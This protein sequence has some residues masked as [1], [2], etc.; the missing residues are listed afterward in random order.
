VQCV[1]EQETAAVAE[2][3]DPYSTEIS[4]KEPFEKEADV[5]MR[6]LMSFPVDV[7]PVTRVQCVS[8]QETADESVSCTQTV[9]EEFD[10]YST[11]MMP[12]M[13][14]IGA[15]KDMTSFPIDALPVA[16]AQETSIECILSTDE[17][18]DS[19]MVDDKLLTSTELVSNVLMTDE[20]SDTIEQ[21]L[22]EQEIPAECTNDEALDLSVVEGRFFK[23]PLV[24]TEFVSYL[25]TSNESPETG[26]HC[27]SKQET[28]A[29]EACASCA[30]SAVEEVQSNWTEM[31]ADPSEEP[32]FQEM[33]PSGADIA[34]SKVTATD[35]SSPSLD[36]LVS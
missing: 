4:S 20:L 26:E 22:N 14:P 9:V 29:V 33:P 10:V 11:E 21:C 18:L 36:V 27:V 24:S 23:E 17:G 6:E 3:V 2:D 25:L 31:V 15:A 35:Q 19:G 8:E 30:L 7:P 28:S 1:S 13:T 32:P 5:E 16:V 34:T 12:E